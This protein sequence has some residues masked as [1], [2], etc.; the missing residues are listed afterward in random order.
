VVTSRTEGTTEQLA[1]PEV[2]ELDP[3]RWYALALLCAASFL[4]ILDAQ[5]V[6]VAAPSIQRD[7]GL[8]GSG[9]QWI[10][11]G[12]ALTF[13]GLLLLGGRAADLFGRRRVFMA[14]VALF[15]VASLLCGLAWTG[16]VLILA[17]I[18]QGASAALMAPAAMAIIITTFPEGRERNRA[19]GMSGAVAAAGGSAGALAGGPLTQGLGWHWIFLLNVPIGLAMLA[20]SPVLLQ[21]S[22][23]AQDGRRVDLAGALTICGALVLLVDGITQVPG[24]GWAAARTLVPLAGSVLL[25]AS[26]LVVES[27]SARPLVPLRIFRSRTLVGGNLVIVSAAVGAY[28]QGLLTSLYAQEVLGYTPAQFGLMTAV[29][30][31]TAVLASVL[32]QR[33]VTRHGFGI[34]AAVSMTAMAVGCALLTQLSASGSFAAD[35]LPG[36]LVLGPGLGAAT[37]AASI[38][39]VAGVAE[40]ESGLASGI[41]NTSFQIGG[42]FGVALLTTIAAARTAQVDGLEDAA[43]TAGF[44]VA[45]AVAAVVS[46]LG[47][48]A[49]AT[50]LRRTGQ[51]A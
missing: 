20:L 29:V 16:P 22:P 10:L 28:G 11:S 9:L 6:T 15:A 31:V 42:A 38:A 1:S 45:F 27:R 3:R 41:S 13:G 48:L 34:V 5:I 21:P 39:A 7:L 8:S 12:Y 33:L 18:V 49:A 50:L 17:R 44:R 43:L 35:L 26:F 4:V 47:A 30:P 32:S 25:L 14:G 19:L 40:R 46:L 2:R 23:A 24:N 51:D 37:V 36:L